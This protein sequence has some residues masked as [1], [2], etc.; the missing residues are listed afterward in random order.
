MLFFLSR[1]CININTSEMYLLSYAIICYF[2]NCCDFLL[3]VCLSVYS[4]RMLEV[5][6]SRAYFLEVIYPLEGGSH[7]SDN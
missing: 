3:D 5:H 2:Y 1:N 6:N 4:T 7:V